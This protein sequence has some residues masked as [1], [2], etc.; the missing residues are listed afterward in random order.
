MIPDRANMYSKPSLP[1]NLRANWYGYKLKAVCSFELP[2]VQVESSPATAQYAHSRIPPVV[3]QTWSTNR[4]GKTH[5]RQLVLFRKNN[6]ELAFALYDDAQMNA[7]MEESWRSHQIYEIYNKARYAQL[8]TDIFR[9]CLV[10]ERGG[11]YFDINKSLGVPICSLLH[12]RAT[13]LISYET[14][15]SPAEGAADGSGDN[16]FRDNIVAQYG[17]GF[18]SGHPLLR[19]LIDG[20]CESYPR[21][22]GEVV[23]YPKQA[24]LHF[25]GPDAFTRAVR[26]YLSQTHDDDLV[27]AGVDFNGA[28]IWNMKGSYVRYLSAPPYKYARRDAIVD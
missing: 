2:L 16:P 4:V 1:I 9:Y 15:I 25:T 19:S 8:A 27:R 17:F 3:H 5:A 14:R 21:F 22:K 20:I 24:I 6:P 10:Y 13:G 11:F 7:Y 12:P 26:Q 28:A 23:A 18:S